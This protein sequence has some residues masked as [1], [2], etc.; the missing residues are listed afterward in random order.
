MNPL[1]PSLIDVIWWLCSCGYLLFVFYALY[2]VWREY[3]KNRIL[4]RSGMLS[5]VVVCVPLFG[6]FIAIFKLKNPYAVR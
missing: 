6:P 1:E 4:L 3:G 2:V 5:L